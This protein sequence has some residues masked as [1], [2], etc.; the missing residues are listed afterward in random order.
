[1][2]DSAVTKLVGVEGVVKWFDTKKG[3]GF[4]VG[5]DDQDIFIH[6]SQIEGD[7]FRV[8]SDGQRVNYDAENGERGWHATRVS[9]L[10]GEIV[11]RPQ[12]VPARSPRE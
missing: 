1:M 4:I 2:N 3:F 12:D 10:E 11:V 5:P 6:F 8:L 7:G 9:V